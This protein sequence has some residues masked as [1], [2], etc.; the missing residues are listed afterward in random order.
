MCEQSQAFREYWEL[1]EL[2]S[3]WDLEPRPQPQ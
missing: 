1:L 3:A 2:E